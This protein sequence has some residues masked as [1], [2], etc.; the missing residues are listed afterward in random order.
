MGSKMK[1][2]IYYNPIIFELYEIY[3]TY[4]FCVQTYYLFGKKL[5]YGTFPILWAKQNLKFLGKV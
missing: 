5:A 2:G 3:K 1:T 4:D